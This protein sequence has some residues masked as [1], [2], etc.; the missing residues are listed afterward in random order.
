MLLEGRRVISCAGVGGGALAGTGGPGAGA[1]GTKE[2]VML[3]VLICVVTQVDSARICENSSSST[4][5]IYALF[6]M[7]VIP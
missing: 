2:V 1:G 7:Y 4:L 6:Y 3:C 5:L